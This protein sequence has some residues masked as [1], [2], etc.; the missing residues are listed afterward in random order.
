MKIGREVEGRK[1]GFLTLF[2]SVAE[3]NHEKIVNLFFQ[4]KFS[5]IY[6]SDHANELDLTA[7]NP[8]LFALRQKMVV[9]IERTMIDSRI[10]EY[11]DIFLV[12]DCP[13]FWN[14]RKTDQIKFSKD[15]SVYSELISNMVY[16]APKDF[17]G[18]VE[19]E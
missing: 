10:A 7:G 19:I 11:L 5:Q 16:T 18:D 1:Q 8:L 17:E 12:I 9:T 13:S 3:L 15:L 2:V 4:H 6:I 14:L